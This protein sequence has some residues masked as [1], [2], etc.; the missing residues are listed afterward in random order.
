MGE[1]EKE[2]LISTPVDTKGVKGERLAH[3]NSGDYEKIFFSELTLF[4]SALFKLR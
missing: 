1:H 4:G 3:E 2:R